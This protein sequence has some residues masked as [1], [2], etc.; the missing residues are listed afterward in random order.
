M[1]KRHCLLALSIVAMIFLPEFLYAEDGV[2]NSSTPEMTMMIEFIVFILVELCLLYIVP[3]FV[4]FLV[5]RLGRS[6]AV[7]ALKEQV[8]A[9]NKE[10]SDKRQENEKLTQETTELR[11][12]ITAICGSLGLTEDSGREAII[13][14]IESIDKLA[15][16]KVQESVSVPTESTTA[17]TPEDRL[18]QQREIEEAYAQTLIAALQ[19]SKDKAIKAAIDDAVKGNPGD[20]K[21]VLVRFVQILPSKIRNSAE[22]TPVPS[23]EITDSQLA[24]QGNWKKLIGWV[25]DQL[26]MKGYTAYDI[27]KNNITKDN[28][29]EE[30]V[31]KLRAADEAVDSAEAVSKAIADDTLT[32]EQKTTLLQRLIDKINSRLDPKKTLP[33]DEEEFIR[34]VVAVLSRPADYPEA[35]AAERQKILQILND[36]LR[37]PVDEFTAEKVREALCKALVNELKSRLNSFQCDGLK[38]AAHKLN[39]AL[40]ESTA[41]KRLCQQLNVPSMEKL[42]EVISKKDASLSQHK[43]NINSLNARISQH[44]QK[45]EAQKAEI[46]QSKQTIDTQRATISQREQTIA[47]KDSTIA[48]NNKKI[49]EQQS[50]ITKQER[51]IREKKEQ[52][53]LLLC[54]STAMVATLRK[55]AQ[56]LSASQPPLLD[57]CSQYDEPKCDQA[58]NDL[59]TAITTFTNRLNSFSVSPGTSPRETRQQIQTMLQTFLTD[60]DSAVSILC[61]YYAYSLLPFMSDRHRRYGVLIN[62]TVAHDYYTIIATLYATFSITLI[63]PALFA[64]GVDTTP[65]TDVTGHATSSLGFLCSQVVNHKDTMDTDTKPDKVVYDL[66]RLGYAIDDNILAQPEVITF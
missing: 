46:T 29:F 42:R 26:H 63:V 62:T 10:L 6:E 55:F 15:T 38:D 12:T 58:D 9:I 37:V 4:S 39:D 5:R 43:Q 52:I 21:A 20:A 23:T 50:T 45:I 61:R 47:T 27:S 18:K 60:A 56:T 25:I 2:T 28:L 13:K 41:A 11:D 35:E 59:R 22:P 34:E 16:E 32:D 33:C 36:T 30:I 51:D 66:V 49:T 24:Q 3:F 8:D 7:R 14:K 17:P 64:H 44:Q 65:Y 48:A 57:P 19:G 31:A 1:M 40:A 53:D 54:D